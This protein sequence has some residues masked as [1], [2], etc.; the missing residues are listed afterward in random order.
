[1]KERFISLVAIAI[2]I[3]VTFFILIFSAISSRFR[4]QLPGLLIGGIIVAISLIIVFHSSYET[5]L[6]GDINR[7]VVAL[8]LYCVATLFLAATL[9]FSYSGSASDGLSQIASVLLL[10]T[11]MWLIVNIYQGYMIVPLIAVLAWS[12]YLTVLIFIGG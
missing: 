10:I 8:V 5:R 4:D 9:P 3:A 2:I 11:T 7:E 6:R 12:L 1:M